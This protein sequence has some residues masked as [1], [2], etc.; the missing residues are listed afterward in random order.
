MVEQAKRDGSALEAVE[1]LNKAAQSQNTTW[2]LGSLVAEAFDAC[3]D[4]DDYR[5]QVAQE[6]SKESRI[7]SKESKEILIKSKKALTSP[8]SENENNSNSPRSASKTR[9]W[10]NKWLE[11]GR[12]ACVSTCYAVLRPHS[13]KS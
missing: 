8:K 5:A 3:Q 9:F 6:E 10:E 1:A 7:E 4:A 12:C 13:S 11:A 2:Q